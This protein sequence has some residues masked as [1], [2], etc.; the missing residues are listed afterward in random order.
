M[1]QVCTLSFYLKDWPGGLASSVR[2]RLSRAPSAAP[3]LL[4]ESVTPSAAA[5][6]SR[7]HLTAY[8]CRQYSRCGEICNAEFFRVHC[9]QK[10]TG[11]MRMKRNLFGL[12]CLIALL[13][14]ACGQETAAPAETTDPAVA[15]AQLYQPLVQAVGDGTATG[16][17]LTDAQIAQAVAELDAA[18]LTAV[19]VDAA[20]P[21][22]HPET[23]AA[24]WAARAAGEKARS[25]SMRSAATADCCATHCASRT[26]P[27]PSRAR[28]LS[29]VTG[30]SASAMPIPMPSRR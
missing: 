25:R 27:I 16:V 6:L 14:T 28:A 19:H 5:A 29:G 21:V 2:N 9:F 8:I 24:F 18:G 23:V 10:M 26:E 1:V 12:L 22:T 15:A 7:Q 17:D 13:L 4:P 30:R 11:G 3:V 20:D